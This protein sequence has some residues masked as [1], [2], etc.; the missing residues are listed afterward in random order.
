MTFVR[1][2]VTV[3]ASS[4]ICTVV[5]VG[6]GIL[7]GYVAPD[8][9]RLWFPTGLPGINMVQVGIGFGLNAGVFSGIVI[10]LGI[11]AIVTH[12]Q[13]KSMAVLQKPQRELRGELPVRA[14][15]SSEAFRSRERRED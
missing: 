12:Y 7:M 11:V 3:A 2:F 4:A 1:A 8:F 5:G 6:L 9:Y 13:L 15:Q 14:G 10:G